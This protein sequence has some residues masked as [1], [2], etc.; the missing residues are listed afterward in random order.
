MGREPHQPTAR[1]TARDQIEC[2]S[3][4]RGIPPDGNQRIRKP[5]G[6]EKM[7]RRVEEKG[8]SKGREDDTPDWTRPQA[9]VK[10]D[11]LLTDSIQRNAL[12]RDNAPLNG[13]NRMGRASACHWYS[14]MGYLQREC[15]RRGYFNAEPH[16]RGGRHG[17]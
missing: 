17:L 5:S 7:A 3:W 9:L 2:R 12:T 4:P 16:H 10:S 13:G 8:R 15:P 6:K 14:E 11:E 1:V